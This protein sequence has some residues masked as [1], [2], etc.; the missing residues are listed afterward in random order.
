MWTLRFGSGGRG[1]LESV[2][3]DDFGFVDGVTCGAGRLGFL[4]L[5]TRGGAGGGSA[6]VL[7]SKRRP[8]GSVLPKNP[9]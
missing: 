3:S 7:F 6:A 1:G 5:S 8:S 9:S 4:D 2:T